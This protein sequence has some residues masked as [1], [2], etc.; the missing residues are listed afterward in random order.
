MTHTLPPRHG[1]RVGQHHRPR[2]LQPG[3][4]RGRHPYNPPQAGPIP[5]RQQQPYQRAPRQP[6]PVASA[7][8]VRPSVVT[9][10]VMG[11]VVTIGIALILL[12]ALGTRNDGG[13][14][15]SVVSSS[16]SE[17]VPAGNFTTATAEP[18]P[19][20]D[21]PTGTADEVALQRLVDDFVDAAG[22]GPS[23][24]WMDYYCA[25]DRAM[26]ERNSDGEIIIPTDGFNERTELTDVQVRGVNARGRLDGEPATFLKESGRWTF[27]MTAE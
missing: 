1:E 21:G 11:A 7:T 14:D 20:T 16:P 23:S 9:W 19:D 3:P 8:D 13:D 24:N 17:L 22:R 26:I 10:A 5:H 27:C 15:G 2:H 18:R 25:S 12:L 6:S 4:P